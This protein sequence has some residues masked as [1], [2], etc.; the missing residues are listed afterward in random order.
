[1][2]VRIISMADEMILNGLQSLADPQQLKIVEFLAQCCFGV[3][4]IHDDGRV[5]GPV[6]GNVCCQISSDPVLNSSVTTYI[7]KLEASGLI[8][9]TQRGTAMVCT[10]RTDSIL[11]ISHFIAQ[12][13]RGDTDQQYCCVE[14]EQP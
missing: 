8:R 3:A 13:S 7:H 9:V 4:S 11:S 14:Q 5:E 2:Y 1:M 10:L 12:V 6:A